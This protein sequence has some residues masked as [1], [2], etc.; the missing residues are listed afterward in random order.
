MRD[1]GLAC[2]I[3]ILPCI[4]SAQDNRKDTDELFD[5]LTG[6]FR[7]DA[8]ERYGTA[9][10]V[11][12]VG[13]NFYLVTAYHVIESVQADTFLLTSQFHDRIYKA[14]LYRLVSLE[15]DIAVVIAK[16]DSEYDA[17]KL[18]LAQSMPSIESVVFAAGYPGGGDLSI[19]GGSV[20]K[21]MDDKIYFNNPNIQEGFSGAPLISESGNLVVGILLVRSLLNPSK[22][23]HAN[24]VS[25]LRAQMRFDHAL[26]QKDI[27]FSLSILDP[28]APY[29]SIFRGLNTSMTR[30]DV[31]DEVKNMNPRRGKMKISN[32]TVKGRTHPITIINYPS[33]K[34]NVGGNS[35]VAIEYIFKANRLAGASVKMDF[36]SGLFRL[37]K[38]AKD[39][40]IK[41]INDNLNQFMT[42]TKIN[43]QQVWSKVI[44]DTDRV[45][46]VILDISE[47]SSLTL[48]VDLDTK[49]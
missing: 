44:P 39:V 45:I 26:N 27:D 10:V 37:P 14:N 46:R 48:R 3:L 18:V 25:N 28:F 2:C 36:Y 13:E 9:F 20:T 21:V 32:E 35:T 4:S 38:L 23:N 6:V 5:K 31:I 11:A 42:S 16:K 17:D 29:L 47:E 7:I 12:D 43:E 22:D 1:F 24:S 41:L 40:N 19:L 8:G 34:A 30:R 15:E 33:I 49:Q